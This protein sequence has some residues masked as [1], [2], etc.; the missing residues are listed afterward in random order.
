M[1]CFAPSNTS[2]R[3]ARA[4]VAALLLA[5]CG[6]AIGTPQP[7]GTSEIRAA[8]AVNVADQL[9]AD[10]SFPLGPIPREAHPQISREQAGEIAVAWARTFG[11]YVREEMERKHGKP[12]DFGALR[13]G[14]R[15]YYAASPYEAAGEEAHPAVRNAFGPQYLVYLV[16]DE[17]PVFSIA[18]AAFGEAVVESG[19]LKLP[20]LFGMEVVPAPIRPGRGF[21][22]PVSPEQAAVTASRASGARVAGVP[23]LIAPGSEHHAQHARWRVPLDRAVK[24]RTR[25]GEERVTR[26]LYV[27]LGGALSLPS[28][29]QSSGAVFSSRSQPHPIRLARR[30]DRPVDY[31]SVTLPAH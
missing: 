3:A 28:A 26:E 21:F 15:A 25:D 5:A 1:R 27:G 29:A 16:D 2:R 9:E 10:G 8:L 4:A 24:A 12:I 14:S 19:M 13:V 11:R 23:E 30:A 22:A 7:L 17:G 6:D 31:V 18:V 20:R